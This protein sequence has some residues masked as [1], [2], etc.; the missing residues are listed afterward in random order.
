MPNSLAI[1]GAGFSGEGRGRGI[2]IEAS[3][4]TVVGALGLVL[5]GWLID[6]V[7]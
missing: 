3:A 2:G 6:N 1:P 5:G 4:G 7:G